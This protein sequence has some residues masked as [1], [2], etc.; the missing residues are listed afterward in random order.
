MAART[1][2]TSE[3]DSPQADDVFESSE[4]AS[5]SPKSNRTLSARDSGTSGMFDSGT[6]DLAYADLCR[7]TENE[8]LLSSKS[9]LSSKLSK[10]SLVGSQ[11]LRKLNDSTMSLSSQQSR[12]HEE[13]DGGN[14]LRNHTH[15]VEALTDKNFSPH[16]SCRDVRTGSP[17]ETE[18]FSDE[19][20]LH[21]ARPEKETLQRRPSKSTPV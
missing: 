16:N 6:E 15:H 21:Y 11:N 20:L 14:S 18:V 1:P 19:V 4:N 3:E 5:D 13:S 10:S 7:N 2:S 12:T 9:S 17:H 8:P